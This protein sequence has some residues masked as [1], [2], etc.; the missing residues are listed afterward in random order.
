MIWIFYDQ[1]KSNSL[2]WL[3]ALAMPVGRTHQDPIPLMVEHI[4]LFPAY[5]YSVPGRTEL[6]ALI[7]YENLPKSSG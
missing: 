2:M 5:I 1:I 7:C 4:L 3:F 6:P